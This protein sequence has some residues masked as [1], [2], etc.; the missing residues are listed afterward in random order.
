MLSSNYMKKPLTLFTI[1]MVLAFG[2]YLF[3]GQT[4][5][6]PGSD[7]T[8][9]S[10]TS[11]AADDVADIALATTTVTT[12]AGEE[13]TYQLAE[14]FEASIAA[15]GLGKARFMTRS[16]DG[17]IF[18]PDL[19]NYNLS[20]SGKVFILDDF[21]EETEEFETV[22]TYL[23]GLR[24]PNSVAFHTDESGQSWIYV[25][26]TAEL[27]RYPYNP[28]DTEPTGEPEVITIF[29]NDQVEGQAS[30]VWHITR[31]IEFRDDRLFV[32]VGSGCDSCEQ[33]EGELRGVIYS[34]D[35]DGS[36]KQVYA[37]GLRNAV[38]F[39]WAEDEL[40]ATEN[41]VDHLGPDAPDG[42]MYR[43][44]EGEHYG[45]PYCYELDGAVVAD[46]TTDWQRDYDCSS[47][48]ESF[49]SFEPRS[50]PLGIDYLESAHPVLEDS[51]LVALHGSFEPETGNGYKIMRVSQQGETTTFMDGFL[52]ENN[53]R[54]GR[55]MSFLQQDENSFFFTDDH[56]GRIY[57]LEADE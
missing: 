40:Y 14:P 16:P 46:T 41:G 20:H 53:E 29:P 45:W 2:A 19:V 27:L 8:S 56:S 39:T 11:S 13:L 54:Q 12:A 32:S 17:R 23:S 49:A 1:L 35:P 28:G 42:V 33:P 26:L 5:D 15:E 55:P 3:S 43:L 4:A 47:A 34:M 51:F 48:P 22:H 52:L 6:A 24:G 31:T 36:D 30:V 37:E 18:V 10:A 21:N 57:Y 7:A 50:A 9:T 44:A 38:G 25:A